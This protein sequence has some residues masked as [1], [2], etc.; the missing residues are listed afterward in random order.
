MAHR[1]IPYVPKPINEKHSSK[2]LCK[3]LPKEL[4]TIHVSQ[5]IERN[6]SPFTPSI[7]DSDLPTQKANEDDG[8]TAES[9]LP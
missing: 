9:T 7:V 6:L 3:N 2:P 5:R 1:F 4:S 8:I